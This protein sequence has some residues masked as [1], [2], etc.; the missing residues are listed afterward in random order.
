[1][2]TLSTLVNRTYKT[3]SEPAAE[4]V[5]L[6][7]LKAA[8]RILSCDFDEELSRLLTT[9][10]RQ[11]ENDTKRRLITQTVRLYLD[12]FP[13][14]REIELRQPP[15]QSVTSIQYLDAE[16]ATQT[17]SAA[18]YTTDLTTTPARIW[19][20]DDAYWPTTDTVPNAVWVTFV[21]GY[22][23][24]SAVPAEAKLAVIQYA[25]AIWNQCG[26]EHTGPGS[27][28]ANLISRLSWTGYGESV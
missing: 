23:A 10:R 1:M 16:G 2:T 20:D 4:P 18:S 19:R 25:K 8:L 28:Y 12:C 15:V 24:A 17:F 14:G 26:G 21:A 13:C 22:G 7:S 27:V 6:D 3:T 9:A 11:V 5:T